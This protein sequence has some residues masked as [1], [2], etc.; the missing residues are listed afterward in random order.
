M[1]VIWLE[2]HLRALAWLWKRLGALEFRAAGGPGFPDRTG[3]NAGASGSHH[4]VWR[5]P[6]PIEPQNS[7]E[8]DEA[9]LAG[10]SVEESS[11]SSSVVDG[12]LSG[13]GPVLVTLDP[14]EPSEAAG[15]PDLAAL[16]YHYE[17]EALV[18]RCASLSM[19]GKDPMRIFFPN[20]GSRISCGL[21]KRGCHL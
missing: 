11:P 19:G 5:G 17:A 8:S 9:R 15:A 14:G 2:K 12:T 6:N 1:L 18:D 10:S 20:P 21:T 13:T 16:L 4:N 3:G 7:L